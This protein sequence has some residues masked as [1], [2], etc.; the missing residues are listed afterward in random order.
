MSNLRPGRPGER[1][2]ARLIAIRDPRGSNAK[3]LRKSARRYR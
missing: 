2:G 3:A 1:G